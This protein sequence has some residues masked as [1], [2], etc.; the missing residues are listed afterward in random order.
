MMMLTMYMTLRVVSIPVC[1]TAIAVHANYSRTSKPR[2][3]RNCYAH[4]TT[5]DCRGAVCKLRLASSGPIRTPVRPPA[6][7]DSPASGL[8]PG[9]SEILILMDLRVDNL[10]G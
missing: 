9:D 7:S 4:D 1:T 5:Q 6:A 3:L 2:R 8:P 10:R